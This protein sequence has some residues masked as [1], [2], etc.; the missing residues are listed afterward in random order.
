MNVYIYIYINE[1]V[2]SEE[3]NECDGPSGMNCL[4]CNELS[5]Y[6]PLYNDTS[7]PETI[8]NCLFFCNSASSGLYLEGNKC[9]NCDTNCLKCYGN[10][11]STCN[12]CSYPYILGLNR[13]CILTNCDNYSNTFPIG[14]RC[15]NC[16]SKCDG[17]INS[18]DNCTSCTSSYFQ[19][20]KSGLCLE[21]CPEKYYS[22]ELFKL[23]QRNIYI[24][25]YSMPQ[26]LQDLR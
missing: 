7:N 15:Q 14:N 11:N 21:I 24:Y 8:S 10:L 25:I 18:P 22:Y 4:S 20:T 2:C 1:L 26:K 6:Y 13:E 17:C 5:E 3:C 16:S 12:A 19:Q 9:K 23:C